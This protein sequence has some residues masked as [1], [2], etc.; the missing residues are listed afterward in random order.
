MN[1]LIIA[2]GDPF[3]IL[4]DYITGDVFAISSDIYYDKRIF[5]APSFE[6]FVQGICTIQYALW[7]NK[8]NELFELIRKNYPQ[9]SF[10]FWE[11]LF[12]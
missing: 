2:N 8:T 9:E 12:L 10:L 11:H 4:I 3:T 6:L 7:H 5:I 1:L